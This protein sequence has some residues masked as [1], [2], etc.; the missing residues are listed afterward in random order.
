MIP[1]PHF[2]RVT[3]V[4][5]ILCM[6]AIAPV[7]IAAEAILCAPAFFPSE[8]R[9]GAESDGK[10]APAGTIVDVLQE[11]RLSAFVVWEK[12]RAWVD[13][14]SLLHGKASLAP[15]GREMLAAP[16]LFQKK[17]VSGS[18][19]EVQTNPGTKVDI[20]ERTESSA[21][22]RHRDVCGWVPLTALGKPSSFA[23][24]IP[25]VFEGFPLEKIQAPELIPS[26]LSPELIYEKLV[27]FEIV[28]RITSLRH[29][30][31][32]PPKN[33]YHTG[34]ISWADFNL[35][36]GPLLTDQ[37]IRSTQ[38]N[39][40]S[41]FTI[42]TA[43]P[44]GVDPLDFCHN[45]HIVCDSEEM[46]GQVLSAK[47]DEFITLTGSL[48]RVS[49]DS[50]RFPNPAE[51]RSSVAGEYCYILLVEQ[52]VNHGKSAP[53]PNAVSLGGAPIPSGS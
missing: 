30:D 2:F 51:W 40:R 13:R 1:K 26:R 33:G 48:V 42:K 44:N 52:M 11:N 39:R 31:V 32:K 53:P 45:F 34:S 19:R 4:A 8:S 14:Q 36:W 25:A 38:G 6:W 22:I 43:L 46:K 23:R 24:K 28:A 27:P 9:S 37:T 3:Q 17:P 20:L 7:L 16:V 10:W 5:A 50:M 49:G 15:I 41:S 12:R 29:Y 47:K 18:A 21:L 35:A